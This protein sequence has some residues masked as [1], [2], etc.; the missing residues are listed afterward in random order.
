MVAFAK[1]QRLPADASGFLTNV[2][3]MEI[4]SGGTGPMLYLATSRGGGLSA[5]RINADGSLTLSGTEAYASQSASLAAPDLLALPVLGNMALLPVGPYDQSL[6]AYGLNSDGTLT[7]KKAGVLSASAALPT[8][9]AHPVAVTVGSA[10]Y[11]YSAHSGGLA[12]DGYQVVGNTGLTAVAA[13]AGTSGASGTITALGEV[14]AGGAQVLLAGFHGDDRVTSY[15]VGASGALTQV[16][17]LGAEDGLWIT[18]PAAIASAQVGAHSYAIVGSA[19]SSTLSVMEVHSDGSLTATDQ[20]LD[21]LNTRFG[22]ADLVT[23]VAQAGHAFVIAAGS[24]DGMSLFVLLPGGRLELLTTVA[25]AT[26]TTLAHAAAISAVAQGSALDVYVSSATEPGLT[27]YQVNLGNF[28]SILEG[29]SGGTV[30][31][32]SHDDILIAHS[33]ADLLKGGGGADVFVFDPAGAAGDGKLGTVLDFTPGT[34][35]LDLSWLPMLYGVGQLGITST[36]KGAE[37]HFGHYWVEV[38]AAVPGPIAASKFTNANVLNVTHQA[39]GAAAAEGYEENTTPSTPHGLTISGGGGNDNITGDLGNDS[40]SGGNGNDTIAGLD[41]NDTIHAGNGS[42][43]VVGGPGDDL[44]YGGDSSADGGDWIDAGEGNN[45]VDGGWGNDTISA[46]AGND[47]LAG[48]DGSDWI[49]G[50]EGANTLRGGDG[51][52]TL[53]GGSGADLLLGGDSAADLRDIIYGG[54]GND[55]IDGGFGNDSI[56]GGDGADTIDGGFGADTLIGNDGN[57]TLN[58]GPLA[59][60]LFGGPGNDFLNGGYGSDRI[61]G[62]AGADRFYHLGTASQGSDWLQDY[63]NADGDVLVFGNSGATAGQFQVNFA[64]THGAGVAGVQE[65]FVVYKPTGQIVWALVDGAAEAH[66]EL[67][68]VGS[69]VLHDLLI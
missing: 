58:G 55:T 3:G 45:T 25:D 56:S 27:A 62:G 10:S 20:V 7:G 47:L 21:D 24:D 44:I 12:P 53:I 18:A 19:G 59:D 37:L 13:V 6:T 61:A 69:P 16:E 38:D 46:G 26:D 30:T 35:R 5:Y 54:A 23:T 68:I 60:L 42:D 8:A 28:G 67:Q 22:G 43:H 49:D 31:G 9:T 17:T 63:R 41:G 4:L 34:D 51:Q 11:L 15:V 52:D 29:G 33:G 65:A 48:G 64:E 57:D 1:L 2:M 66:I 39:V 36:A 40:L 14:D 50:G 32:T